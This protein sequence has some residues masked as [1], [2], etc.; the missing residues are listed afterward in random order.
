YYSTVK[1]INLFRQKIKTSK[2]LRFSVNI[3]INNN[4]W[5]YES[6]NILEKEISNIYDK[7]DV[8]NFIT[9]CEIEE[10]VSVIKDKKLKFESII[11]KSKDNIVLS[12]IRFN[13][14]QKIVYKLKNYLFFVID[15]GY[16]NN[17]QRSDYFVE[18]KNM[19]GD[20]ISIVIKKNE[21]NNISEIVINSNNNEYQNKNFKDFLCK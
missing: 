6:L 5:S 17:D 1:E 2:S 14:A 4:Y 13:I 12:Q 19:I 18:L 3:L 11:K 9:F 15:S 10:I 8:N 21:K 7:F 20:N 16:V